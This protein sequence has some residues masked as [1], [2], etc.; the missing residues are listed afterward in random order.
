MPQINQL[1]AIFFSQLF[2]LLV[3]FGIIY[4]VIGRGMVPKIR[5]TVETREKRIADDLA[6]AQA[7]RVAADETEAAWRE[8]MDA[9]RAEAAK[10]SNE[11]KQASAKDTETKVHAAADKLNAKLE[12]AEAKIRVA[13]DAARSEIETVAADATKEIVSRL[14]GKRVDQKQAVDAV[15]AEMNV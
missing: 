1:S 10:L 15:K 3:V 6:H 11:A 4:F 12:Q 2:W 9:A 7:A 8:R 5:S 14:T 13:L